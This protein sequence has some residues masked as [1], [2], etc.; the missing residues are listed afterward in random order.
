MAD[1]CREVGE[2]FPLSLAQRRNET[3]VPPTMSATAYVDLHTLRKTHSANINALAFSPSGRYLA[4]GSDDQQVIIWVVPSGKEIYR[5]G[6]ESRVD[7]LLWNPRWKDTLI[8][9][10]ENGSLIQVGG[11]SLVRS[12]TF[13]PEDGKPNFIHEVWLRA[14]RNIPWRPVSHLLP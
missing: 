3:S 8:I 9:A 12:C 1:T 4:S 7:A 11:F 10:C 13:R 5:I 14:S 2:S 6:F